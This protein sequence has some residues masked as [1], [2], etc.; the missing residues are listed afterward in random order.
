MQL[1]ISK[2]E[3]KL[4]PL[5]QFDG[6]II[7]ITNK[8]SLEEALKELSE[9]P[10]IGF[11]TETRPAF[12]KGEYHPTSLVQL[13][14][15][16]KCFLIRTLK[17]GITR[18]LIDFFENNHILKIG[19][20]LHDDLKD[21]KK[22]KHFDPMGFIDLN[23]TAR[24]MGMD[25]IGAKNLTGIFLKHRISKNQQTSNWEN[26]I[27]TDAQQIYAATDAWIC[28]KVYEELLRIRPD[29]RDK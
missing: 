8:D 22:I 27:L 11:D 19:I 17:T 4:L 29:L 13:A 24:G 7:P 15:D 9:Y 3:L 1:S 21:L 12:K 2:E 18:P 23:V 26:Q 20:A 16:D 6:E 10:I 5:L 28:L 25:N 14:T